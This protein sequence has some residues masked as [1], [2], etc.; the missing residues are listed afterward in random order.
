MP[1]SVLF[2]LV[3]VQVLFGINFSTS[4]IVVG[5]LEPMPFTSLRFLIAGV[6]LYGFSYVWNKKAKVGGKGIGLK[7]LIISSV[8]GISFSQTLFILGLKYTTSINT[9]LLTTTIPVFTVLISILRGQVKSNMVLWLGV[10]LS[11]MGVFFIKNPL[12]ADFD[13]S[14]LW[15][16]LLV[17]VSCFFLAAYISYVKNIFTNLEPIKTTAQIFMVGGI[18]LIPSLF[19]TNYQWDEIMQSN[20][21]ICFAYCTLGGTLLTYLLNNIAI[22]KVAPDIVAIFIYIQPVVAC[23]IGYFFMGESLTLGH[24]I[25]AAIVLLGVR[26][27]IRKS[28]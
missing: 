4:K 10:F 7:A 1:K 2:I 11:L 3:L 16:N 9:S 27:V 19:T 26:L 5:V 15:G 22:K 24:F 21:I 28:F 14:H 8:L 18:N 23:L 17:L 20:F 6:F 12:S 13:P 25:G